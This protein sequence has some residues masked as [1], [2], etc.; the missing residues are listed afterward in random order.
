M[1]EFE[2][3]QLYY[4][5]AVLEYNGEVEIKSLNEVEGEKRF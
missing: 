3:N 4:Y 2:R 5:F 1:F